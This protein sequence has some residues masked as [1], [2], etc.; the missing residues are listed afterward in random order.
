V[1]VVLPGATAYAEDALNH[2][3]VAQ[4][5]SGKAVRYYAGGAWDRA[6]EITSR[7]QWQSYVRAMAERY[8]SP[9][10]VSTRAVP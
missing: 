5:G 4:A 7:E 10:R 9:V 8:R 1:A 2:L 6:G 3:I